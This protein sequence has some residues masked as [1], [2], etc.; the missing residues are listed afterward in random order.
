KIERPVIVPLTDRLA[1]FLER[2]YVIFNFISNPLIDIGI[3]F[4]L[5]LCYLFFYTPLADIYYFAPVPW[6]VYLFAFH[7]TAVLLAF[8]ETKKHFRRKGHPLEY[9]G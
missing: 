2:H 4:E 8:E 5:G 6:H 1:R 3:L 7:G 9:L